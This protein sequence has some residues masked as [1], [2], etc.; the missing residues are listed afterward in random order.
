LGMAGFAI[1][2]FERDEET[3]E[4][5]P[6]EEMQP[7]SLG[8]YGT[9]DHEP[10]KAYYERLVEWWHGPDGSEGWK[11]VQRLMRFLGLD[12]DDPPK[13]FTPELHKSFLK[14]LMESPCWL[15]LLM[16]TD[17]LGTTQRFNEPGAAGDVNWS[18]RLEASLDELEKRPEYAEN[19]STFQNLI[20]KTNRLPAKLAAKGAV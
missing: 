3:R 18:Q 5:E 4:F 7:L 15:A 20:S 11:E 10:L 1:P 14:T 17:L 12:V 2:I 9:H 16:I 8:T 19:I 13:E 6:S